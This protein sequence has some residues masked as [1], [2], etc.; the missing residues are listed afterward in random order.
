MDN[1]ELPWNWIGLSIN[2][3]I[4]WSFVKM[5]PDLPWNGYSMNYNQN[6][7]LKIVAQIPHLRSQLDLTVLLNHRWSFCSKL[8]TWRTRSRSRS[9]RS[10]LGALYVL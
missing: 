1:K 7:D 5:N 3:G 8:Y 9:R 10:R 6:L 4:D 2:S